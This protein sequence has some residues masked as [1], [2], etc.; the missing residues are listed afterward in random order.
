M[1]GLNNEVIGVADYRPHLFRNMSAVGDDGKHLTVSHNLVAHVVG[2]V[3]WHIESHYLETANLHLVV[4]LD[5]LSKNGLYLLLHHPVSRHSFVNQICGPHRYM[6]GAAHRP[7]RFYVVGMV[8][9]EQNVVNGA[10]VDSV[11]G[12]VLLQLSYSYANIY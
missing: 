9:G 12:E 1:I 7:H 5:S 3:V 11:V 6:I 10:D 8:V 2:T 4:L